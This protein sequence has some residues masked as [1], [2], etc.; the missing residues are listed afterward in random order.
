[1]K[2]KEL[3]EILRKV[4]DD[5][6]MD[7]YLRRNLPTNLINRFLMEEMLDLE[8]TKIVD[9]FLSEAR[10][11]DVFFKNNSEIFALMPK[12]KYEKLKV[13]NKEIKDMIISELANKKIYEGL[14]ASLDKIPCSNTMDKKITSEKRSWSDEFSLSDDELNWYLSKYL[15]NDESNIIE[16][17]NNMDA[18]NLLLKKAGVEYVEYYPNSYPWYRVKLHR[19]VNDSETKSWSEKGH[20]L[21]QSMSRSLYKFI[22]SLC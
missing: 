21:T 10:K 3:L 1:M 19:H 2:K 18:C 16:F 20:T 4:K 7:E 8:K 15:F 17:T 14:F 12:E 11:Q 5:V 6:L 13:S 22:E 9:N